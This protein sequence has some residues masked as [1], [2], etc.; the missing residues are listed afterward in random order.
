[1]P[2]NFVCIWSKKVNSGLDKNKNSKKADEKLFTINTNR[3]MQMNII[4]QNLLV[5]RDVSR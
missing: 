2:S 3:Y 1:M 4:Q 5:V